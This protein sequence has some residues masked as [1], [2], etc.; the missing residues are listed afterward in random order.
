ME[1][2]YATIKDVRR[3]V[4]ICLEPFFIDNP[5]HQRYMDVDKIYLVG[6]AIANGIHS[7]YINQGEQP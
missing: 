6:E 2:T 3:P 7:W 1:P 4:S 5:A